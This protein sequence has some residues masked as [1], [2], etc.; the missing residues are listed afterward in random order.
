MVDN[1][2]PWSTSPPKLTMPP[3]ARKQ[4]RFDGGATAPTGSAPMPGSRSEAT[5]GM[6]FFAAN[7]VDLDLNSEA[8]DYPHL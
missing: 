7:A 5:S 4:E 6:E 2:A 8:P 1:A 3:G